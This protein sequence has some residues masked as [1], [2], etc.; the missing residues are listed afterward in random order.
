MRPVLIGIVLTVWVGMLTPTIVVA[1]NTYDCSRLVSL[2]PSTT[3]LLADLGLSNRLV[4]VSRYCSLPED[5]P[6][7]IR[8]GGLLDLNL[9]ALV[10]LQPTMVLSLVEHRDQRHS[11]EQL[12]IPTQT[13]DHRHVSGILDS[14]TTIGRICGISGKAHVLRQSIEDRIAR[15]V[16]DVQGLPERK[17]LVVIGG[18]TRMGSVSDVWVSGSDGFYSDLLRLSGASNV[19]SGGSVSAPS[20]SQEG[21]LKLQPDT[22]LEIIPDRK[23]S[24]EEAQKIEADWEKTPLFGLQGRRV[25]I[26]TG[27]SVAVPG[28][29]F[30]DFLEELAKL[31]HGT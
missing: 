9:E 14:I 25:V 8:L 5:A 20:L 21:I 24:A 7:A 22:I 10:G 1:E 16:L 19:Y 18:G 4:G 23:V 30:I 13:L 3:Q 26:A 31:L 11:L 15:V 17:V 2:A 29:H 28:P 6:Q 27:P 12:G